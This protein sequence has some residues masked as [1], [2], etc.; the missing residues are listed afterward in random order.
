[1]LGGVGEAGTPAR[2]VEGEMRVK[3]RHGR[4][5]ARWGG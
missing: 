2:V 4:H 1:M 3:E 5:R